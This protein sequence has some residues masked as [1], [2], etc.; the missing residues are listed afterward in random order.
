MT[1]S[2]DKA[3]LKISDF[4]LSKVIAPD[5]PGEPSTVGTLC[6]AAPEIFLGAPCGIEVDFWSLG[7]IIYMLLCGSLPFDSIADKEVI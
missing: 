3:E 2:S 6:Y 1:D 7:V 4:G 5:A